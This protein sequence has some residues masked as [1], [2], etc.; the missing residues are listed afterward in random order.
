MPVIYDEVE[1]S[2]RHTQFGVR[3]QYFYLTNGRQ[4]AFVA[5]KVLCYLLGTIYTQLQLDM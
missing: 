1:V 5:A 4:T 2:A 3:S